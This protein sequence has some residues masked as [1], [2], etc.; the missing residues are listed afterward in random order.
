MVE[1]P[2]KY[3]V[4]ISF[5]GEDRSL[6]EALADALISRDI[7]VFYDKWVRLNK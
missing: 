5:A 1:N 6:A 4:A 2:K 3:E 7:A